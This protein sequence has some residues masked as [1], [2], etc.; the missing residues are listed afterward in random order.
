MATRSMPMPVSMFF[1]G[2]DPIGGW[3]C[4]GLSSPRTSCMKTRFQISR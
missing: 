4:L 3:P 2:S 1:F